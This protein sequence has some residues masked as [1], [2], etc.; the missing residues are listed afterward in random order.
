MHHK[1]SGEQPLICY[2]ISWTAAATGFP[3]FKTIIKQFDAVF[4]QFC[5]V[6]CGLDRIFTEDNMIFHSCVVT[7]NDRTMNVLGLKAVK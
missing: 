7:K 5:A 6:A 4:L 2:K 3:F 1:T